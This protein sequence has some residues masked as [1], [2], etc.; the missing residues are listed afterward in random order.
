MAEVVVDVLNSALGTSEDLGP[1]APPGS[2]A[3]EVATNRPRDAHLARVFRLFGRPARTTTCDCE[4]SAEPT[5]PQDLFRMTDPALLKKIT[6]GR[7]AKLLEAK[8]A[9][10]EVVEEL[11]LA[12]LS[13]WPDAN[14]KRDALDHVRGAKDR[15]AAFA[16]VV[17]ALINT[18]EF[19]LNH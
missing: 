8:K 10:A 1:D 12:T 5:I 16:D 4:R 19:I 7:L 9:D 13:R 11:F 6:T 14:E 18:R 3:I 2:H 17:W 15:A